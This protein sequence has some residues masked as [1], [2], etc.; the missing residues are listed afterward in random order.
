MTVE[1]IWFGPEERPLFGW[2]HLPDDSL[3]REGVVI[4]PPLGGEGINAYQANRELAL[5]LAASGFAVLRFDY[6]ATGN[7]AGHFADPGRVAAW[8]LSIR[9]AIDL[10]KEHGLPQI[11]V[12]AMRAG[13][14]LAAIEL[15]RDE[16]IAASL[17]L[18]DPCSSGRSFL[19][20]QRALLL[21]SLGSQSLNDDSFE[22][23]GFVYTKETVN[24]LRQ[25]QIAST[26]GPL[27]NRVLV[28]TRPNRKPEPRM[29]TRL[30]MS[31]VEWGTA[32]GQEELLNP[33]SIGD[34]PLETIAAIVSWL[35]AGTGSKSVPVSISFRCSAVVGHD[36]TGR[37]IVE[38]AVTLGSVGLFGIATDPGGE[39]LG[40]TIL[41]LNAGL[42][43]Q[44]GP[45]R[46][47]VELSRSFAQFGLRS[48][49]FDLSG[50]GDSPVREH[51]MPGILRTPEAFDDLFAV[52]KAVS[53]DDPSNVVLIGLCAGGYQA[54]EGGLDFHPKGIC[55]I[56]PRLMFV[57]PELLSG[58]ID[59][60]RKAY[61]E[62]KP[63]LRKVANLLLVRILRRKGAFAAS[64]TW[65]M[66]IERRLSWLPKV[67]WW[68]AFK[69]GI[70]NAPPSV[71]SKLVDSGVDTLVICGEVDMRPLSMAD[72]GTIRRLKQQSWFQLELVPGLDHGILAAKQRE[73]AIQI[74]TDHIHSQFAPEKKSKN[75]NF[76]SSNR[77]ERNIASSNKRSISK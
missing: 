46:Q 34:P 58:S 55:A 66:L 62:T 21:L 38:R 57:P 13:A 43:H 67:C 54:I 23:P 65:P 22:T 20:E 52:A 26:T 68:I 17:V 1:P 36:S 27:A 39:L 16:K 44:I 59:P 56:N 76:I 41:F 72:L 69:L 10:L 50:L 29:T 75:Y 61:Q 31:H 51:L 74:I 14:T 63:W 73:I 25:C 49:R 71:L 60:R 53:P 6:D 9:T 7:S 64:G 28:L 47:W 2:I 24:K 77:I 35:S 45:A 33:V 42:I 11:S 8:C 48:V 3:A 32:H 37:P 4:C 18:W 40:P 5:Q 70:R 30:S 19:N 15:D 12:V